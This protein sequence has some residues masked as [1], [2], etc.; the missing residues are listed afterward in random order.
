MQSTATKPNV[1]LVRYTPL[2]IILLLDGMGMGIIIPILNS[3]IMQA[4]ANNSSIFH[5]LSPEALYGWTIGIFMLCIF[6]ASVILGTLSDCYGRKK[7]LALCLFG[8]ALGYLLS[9]FAINT[10]SIPLLI[11]GRII[12]GFTAGNQ[13]IAQAAIVDN[14]P[15]QQ[16]A[17]YI[18]LVLLAIAI[19]MISGP[20]LSGILINDKLLPWF[21]LATPMYFAAAISLISMLLLIFLPEVKAAATLHDKKINS[22]SVFKL[23]TE[24]FTDA[25]IKRLC[26]IFLLFE[27]G[28]S[29]FYLFIDMFLLNRY[30][31]SASHQSF[32]MALLGIGWVIGFGFLTKF[33]EKRIELKYSIIAAAIVQIILTIVV[34]ISHR[35]L[36]TWILAIPLAIVDSVIF[37][38]LL[39]IF[40]NH[41]NLDD[42]GWVMGVSGSISA[43]AFG[44]TAIVVGYLATLSTEMPLLI[45][46]LVTGLACI[47]TLM[48]RR[49]I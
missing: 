41:A 16:K 5:I 40:S 13:S 26:V 14:A 7:I 10:L 18:S 17:F 24:A 15:K 4:T 44:L 43:V 12:D 22:F 1:S 11:L 30:E 39:A 48:F 8:S 29:S 35:E 2:F 34:I 28:W 47:L 49:N 21:N 32:Y 45:S 42:Q 20:M 38:N 19:G 9:G 37:A 31:L 46:S 27:I 23:L 36:E 6:L 25:S 3:F 33:L